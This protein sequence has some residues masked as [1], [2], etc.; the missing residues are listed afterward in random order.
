M[1]DVVISASAQSQE[2]FP[3][4][5]LARLKPRVSVICIFLATRASPMSCTLKLGR[6]AS[7]GRQSPLA[8]LGALELKGND[9]LSLG[10]GLTLRDPMSADMYPPGQATCGRDHVPL[11]RE[12][13]PNPGVSSL[14][15][16]KNL[17]R[18]AGAKSVKDCQRLLENSNDCICG[19]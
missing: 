11:Q 10:G 15:P 1:L 14:V 16:N 17:C 3:H 6:E 7:R 5:Y 12:V 13:S 9:G 4:L 8:P 19:S 2:F 18:M